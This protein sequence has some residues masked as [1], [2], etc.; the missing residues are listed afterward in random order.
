MQDKLNSLQSERHVLSGLI[1]YPDLYFEI[2]QIYTDELFF[3]NVHK[4]IYNV[5]GNLICKGERRG[6]SLDIVL[7]ANKI[8]DLGIKFDD[9]INIFDYL[10]TFTFITISK[11]GCLETAKDLEKLRLC[12][13]IFKT[14]ENIIKEVKNN[15]NK[16]IEEI[17][18]NIDKMYHET[19]K[20]SS[21]KDSPKLL[22]AN[23]I[24]LIESL[25]KNPVSEMG[26]ITPHK[27]FNLKFGGLRTG[28]IYAFVS[29]SGEG[30]TTYLDD[31]AIQATQLNP[32]CKALILDT[33][34]Q[35][36]DIK[37]RVASAISN[38]P[39]W[40]LETGNW[41]NKKEYVESWNKAKKIIK[42]NNPVYHLNV[43]GKPIQELC[44]LIRR[45]Y[46]KHINKE[47]GESCIIVYDYIKITGEKDNQLKE[48]QL[49]GEKVN[50]LKELSLELNVPLLTACQLNRTAETGTDDSSAIALSDRLLWFATFVGIFRR[51]RLEEIQEHGQQFGTHALIPLKYRF[52]GRE[53]FGH[54]DLIRT[55]DHN[56]NPKYVRNFLNYTVENFKVTEHGDLKLILRNQELRVIQGN[57]PEDNRD[58]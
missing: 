56:G 5:I 6:E 14:G 17:I 43:A 36:E 45:W 51:K 18:D 34:M 38:I 52:Q 53:A 31:L 4:A 26:L 33:E 23:T 55:Q 2:N 41:I 13:D 10:N 42:E 58:L 39:Q 25:A 40:W 29:R 7:I 24:D 20:L 15:I 19:V 28:N 46:Y 11:N 37:F 3:N 30:K 50:S 1:K 16:P 22:L 57:E 21:V 48:Y 49:I 9:N 35:T 32:G 54:H 8:N 12:R 27:D 44:S 47:K